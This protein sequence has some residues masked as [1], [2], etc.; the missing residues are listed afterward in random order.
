MT[1]QCGNEALAAVD[2]HVLKVLKDHRWS[3]KKKIPK[4]GCRTHTY[5]VVLQVTRE[6]LVSG[7]DNE[8]MKITGRPQPVGLPTQL[9]QPSILGCRT[10]LAGNLTNLSFKLQKKSFQGHQ[11]GLKRLF[12]LKNQRICSNMKQYCVHATQ[13]CTCELQVTNVDLG[14]VSLGE[15]AENS[16]INSC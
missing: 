2:Q 1:M 9:V 4:Y 5:L 12:A 13:C 7:V 8:S 10:E 3:K 11:S 15:T 6:D 14:L 16:F